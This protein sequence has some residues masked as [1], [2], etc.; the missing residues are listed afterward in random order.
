MKD[1]SINGIDFVQRTHY[2]LDLE[3]LRVINLIPKSKWKP[4]EINGQKVNTPIMIP[5]NFNITESFVRH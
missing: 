1:G 4:A 5:I 3:A 2:L